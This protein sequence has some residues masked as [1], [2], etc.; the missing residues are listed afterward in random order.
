VSSDIGNYALHAH[1]WDWGGY[2][3]TE[4]FEYWCNYAQQYGKNVLMPMC[5]LGEIAAYMARKG[6]T[7]TAFD[8]T[9][10]MIAEGKKRFGDVPGMQLIEA[11]ITDFRFNIPPA[12]FCFSTDFGHLHTLGDIK[13]AL[14]CINAHLRG[15]GGLV[16][17]AGLPDKESKYFPPKTFIPPRQ[18][19]SNLKVWKTGDT[20]IDA[21]TSRTYISQTVYMEDR[22]GSV[23]QFDHSFYLQSYP[24]DEWI[25]AL[26]ECGFEI[27]HEYRSREKE[28]WREADGLWIAEAVKQSDPAHVN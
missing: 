10:E 9:P 26:T 23:K 13:K 2:D 17:E 16:I 20:R 22:S 19:Y 27:K 28:L 8:I 25:A 11:D 5:A 4:E 15:G 12:D 6:F 24:R 7:V 1:I 3:R 21:Q 14:S 18:V